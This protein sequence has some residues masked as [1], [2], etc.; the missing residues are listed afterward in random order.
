MKKAVLSIVLILSFLSLLSVNVFAY[1]SLVSDDASLFSDD[2]IVMIEAAAETFA[3]EKDYSLAVVTTDNA[4]GQTAAEYADNYYD[5]LIFGSGWS[6][7][8]LLFLIDMDNREVYI[9]TAGECIDVYESYIDYIIDSGYDSLADGYYADCILSMI[10]AASSV[11]SFYGED[12]EY[13]YDDEYEYGYNGEY[14]DNYE[15]DYNYR[16]PVHSSNGIDFGHII[17]YIIASLGFAFVSVLIVKSRYKNTGK[18][19]EFDADDVVLNLTG[20]ND[21]VIS[22]NV[23]TTRIPKNNNHHRPGGMGGGSSVHRSGGGVRHGGGGRK[24]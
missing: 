24:F 5:D 20:S 17:F 12:D 19:D 13:Y 7:N 18:G 11:N 4:L 6:E 2:E 10:D 3:A 8:G 16:S 14:Y 21:N 15:Y 22:R 23:V 1:N 9:S